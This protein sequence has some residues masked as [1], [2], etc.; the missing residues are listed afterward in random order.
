MY[1]NGSKVLYKKPKKWCK[2]K[3]VKTIKMFLKKKKQ[4]ASVCVIDIER[5]LE[6]KNSVKKNKNVNIVANYI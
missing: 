2:K 3:H 4:K 5:F 6:K 1:K